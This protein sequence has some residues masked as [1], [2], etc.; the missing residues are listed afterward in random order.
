MSKDRRQRTP[1]DATED[2]S[3][4]KHIIGRLPKKSSRN[5]SFISAKDIERFNQIVTH[6]T[7]HI[8][9]DGRFDLKYV[10][11]GEGSQY[12][13]HGIYFEQNPAVADIYRTMGMTSAGNNIDKHR[14]NIYFVDIPENHELLNWYATM[15]EQSKQVKANISRMVQELVRRGYSNKQIL[16]VPDNIIFGVGST[17]NMQPNNISGGA[18]YQN[19]FNIFLKQDKSNDFWEIKKRRAQE[20][21]SALFN[22][23]GISGHRYLD[24][25]S[26]GNKQGT[27]NFV[28][29]NTNKAKIIG[30]THDSDIDARYAFYDTVRKKSGKQDS[31]E[32]YNQH[33]GYGAALRLDE[34]NGNHYLIDNLRVAKR[35]EKKLNPNKRAVSSTDPSFFTWDDDN[36]A[37]KTIWN[38][39]G[40]FRGADGQWKYELPYGNI[41]TDAFNNLKNN[42]TRDKNGNDFIESMP[43]S[44]IF[45]APQLFDAYQSLRS[46]PVTFEHTTWTSGAYLD[47]NGIV[48]NIKHI[49]NPDTVRELLIHEIQHWIQEVEGFAYGGNG[50]DNMLSLFEGSDAVTMNGRAFDMQF[51]H[52][53][54]YR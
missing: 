32:T 24:R 1:L 37:A 21:T 33:I 48:V 41:I 40:W 14:G 49:N 50:N 2:I 31:S 30:I 19:I 7:G 52:K 26:R 25:R 47:D 54:N 13:G 15:D 39:T 36:S 38:A 5:N 28:I 43:L 8:I 3:R 35:M 53:K 6:A 11:T 9:A 18:L 17:N 22:E 16:G 23:F 4:D 29:W 20:K 45:D 27:Y 10:G 42:I 44:S 34:R 51:F 12:F 46:L